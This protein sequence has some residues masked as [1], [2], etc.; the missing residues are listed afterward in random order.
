MEITNIHEAKSQLSKLMERPGRRGSDIAR[1]ASRWSASYPSA[2]VTPLERGA[3]GRARSA[4]PRA[5]MSY[6]IDSAW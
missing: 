1:E 5:L 3:N 2:K 6:L 4:S